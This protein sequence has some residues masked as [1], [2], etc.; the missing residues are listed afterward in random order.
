M[1]AAVRLYRFLEANFA[2]AEQMKSVRGMTHDE[3][4]ALPVAVDLVTAGQAYGMG[5]TLAY[6]LAKRGE[7]PCRVL[8]VGNCYR[9]TRADLLRGLGETDDV[10]AVA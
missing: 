2:M 4:M 9:V 7:F 6:D 5:R 3:L 8:R 1:M 10:K